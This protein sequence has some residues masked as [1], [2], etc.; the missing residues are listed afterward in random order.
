MIPVTSKLPKNQFKCFHCRL[1]FSKREGDWFDWD[2]MQVNL[3]KP[4]DKSTEE[5]PERA[6]KLN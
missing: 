3:C 5:R 2:K 6:R 4:C 1:V